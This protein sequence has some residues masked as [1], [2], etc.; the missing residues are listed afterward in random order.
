[1][2]FDYL[3]PNANGYP[4]LMD[5]SLENTCNLKCIMCDASLSS[6]IQKEKKHIAK[7]KEFIYDEKFLLQLEEFIPHL[8]HAVFTGGEPFLINTYYTI[9]E[10]MI[11]V[12]PEIQINI[13]T[14]GTIWNKRIENLL[15]KGKFNITISTDSFVK[16]T[17]ETIRIG[18]KFNETLKHIQYF[19]E[20]CNKQDTVFTVTICPMQINRFEIP[21]IVN[22]CNQNAWNF[23]YNIVL[24]PWGQALWSLPILDLQKL[25]SFYESALIKVD[26]DISAQNKKHFNSLISLLKTWE[27]KMRTYYKT[28]QDKKQIESLKKQICKT[29]IRRAGQGLDIEHINQERIMKILNTM[30]EILIQVKFLNYV[31]NIRENMLI[32]EFIENDNDTIAD[33]LCI[34]SFNL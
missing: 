8:K 23:T 13:T 14:N 20:Y 31:E 26:N 27:H 4:V 24:K 7:Q 3:V 18:A 9:W 17:Y 6:S 29:I 19:A 11:N 5:F 30:P 2:S 33:H 12:N 16:E 34:V 22:R 15:K 32:K 28:Q 1:L 10:R 21:E 25:I